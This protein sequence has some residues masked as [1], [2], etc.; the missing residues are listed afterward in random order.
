MGDNDES[1]TVS[2]AEYDYLVWFVQYAD[3]G[4]ADGDVRDGMREH[5]ESSTG[6]RVPKGWRGEEDED[7]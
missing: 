4:P 3:F 5:Y 1:V 2:R 6:K 7:E